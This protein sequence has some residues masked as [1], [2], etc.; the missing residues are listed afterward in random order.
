MLLLS[1]MFACCGSA[2]AHRLVDAGGIEAALSACGHPNWEGVR[3]NAVWLL[4]NA[5]ADNTTGL[6]DRVLDSGAVEKIIEVNYVKS[7]RV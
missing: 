7:N 5:G 1:N 4:G 3:L 6:K 2:C